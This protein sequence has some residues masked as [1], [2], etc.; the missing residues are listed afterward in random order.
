MQCSLCYYWKPTQLISDASGV[1][2]RDLEAYCSQWDETMERE[3]Y[4]E[5]FEGKA[6]RLRSQQAEPIR[7]RVA[8]LY[9][10]SEV[11]P[12]T[13][14][15]VRKKRASYNEWNTKRY[16]GDVLYPHQL[17]AV[18]RFKEEKA[19]ALF[20]EVGTG[21]SATALAIAAHKWR[22]GD[23]N[24]LLIIAPNAV[25]F[26]WAMEQVPEWLPDDI[27]R[28]VQ[29]FGGS[30]GAK[31]TYPFQRQDALHILITNIDTFSTPSKWKDIILW[32]NHPDTKCM[33][34]LDE[35][36]SIK[37][38]SAKR[39]ERVLYEFNEV[40]RKGKRIIASE[41]K[42]VARC[43]LTGTPATNGA[44]DLWALMEFLQPNFFGR[45]WYSFRAYYGMLSTI[46]TA[47]G[48]AQTL[49]NEGIWHSIKGIQEYGLA[50][51]LFGVSED[52]FNTIHAQSKYSG[53]YKHIDELKQLVDKVAMYK[54]IRDCIDM[55]D[56]VY[57]TKAIEMSEEQKQAYNDMEHKLLVEYDTAMMTA[58]NKIVAL[59]RLQQI[60]SGFIVN[61]PIEPEDD[62]DDLDYQPGEV[63]W[64]GNKIPK[65]EL[66]LEDVEEVAKPCII[67]TRF[68]AEAS[69]I[70]DALEKKYRVCLMTGW[71]KVG[72][73]EEFKNG[74]YDI[75][76]ANIRVIG[77]G[78]NLQNACQMF[79][80][81]NTFSLE[82]RLQVEGRIFRTGQKHPCVYTDYVN[83]DTVD[84]KVTSALQQKKQL[85]DYIRGVDL[86]EII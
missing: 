70:Y 53:A 75:M 47:T 62:P 34:I 28:E 31:D 86:K 41:P 73:I 22:K 79:F 6:E 3:F 13:T 59:I 60:S 2:Y 25:H 14:K 74:D 84:T 71:K 68:S 43:I 69:R 26:Q 21:K 76:V 58:A 66:L 20:F 15:R 33:I 32:H 51:T 29:C 24:S 45:N 37:S 19:I 85:L 16:K 63:V 11:E 4:C 50:Y 17:E 8:E 30:G 81:S 39:T 64:L 55:P 61:S 77:K 12:E 5:S 82:D 65:M 35:A 7:D 72:S 27:E 44:M 40:M 67:V 46:Q 78:F 52:T 1:A 36:T 42:S 18:D 48:T 9:G 56:Q 57:D 83:Y 38:V 10:I 23:I 54:L 80:Y 49:I